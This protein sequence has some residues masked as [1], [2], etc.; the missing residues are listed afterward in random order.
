MNE[1][2]AHGHGKNTD[3]LETWVNSH[4]IVLG[5]KKY[6]TQSYCYKKGE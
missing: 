5:F 2:L 3:Y 4:N 1:F 6:Y